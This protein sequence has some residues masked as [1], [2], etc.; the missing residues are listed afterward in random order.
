MGGVSHATSFLQNRLKTQQSEEGDG[1]GA[2][3]DD[4]DDEDDDHDDDDE[5]LTCVCSPAG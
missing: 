3:G 1:G 4:G 5:G 2:R